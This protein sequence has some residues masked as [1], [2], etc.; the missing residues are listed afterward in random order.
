MAL[1]SPGKPSTSSYTSASPLKHTP[2]CSPFHS[3]TEQPASS[4]PSRWPPSPPGGLFRDHVIWE[5]SLSH[6]TGAMPS[7]A[8]VPLPS[9]C[10]LPGSDLSQARA[11]SRAVPG[12]QSRR[13][14]S[15]GLWLSEQ[16]PPGP[17]LWHGRLP[18]QHGQLGP[19]T[20]VLGPAI[21]VLMTL[22]GSLTSNF[23]AESTP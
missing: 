11:M 5:T 16:Q 3:P 21:S 9:L 23:P 8:S 14:S 1:H 19:E 2:P 12:S 18:P 10:L 17:R 4:K 13:G 15:K 6:K 20:G 22:S 7:W